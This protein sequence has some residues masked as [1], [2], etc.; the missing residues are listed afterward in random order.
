M[1]TRYYILLGI[2]VL[3]FYAAIGLPIYKECRSKGFSIYY[4]IFQMP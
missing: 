3:A 2:V 4:C 1:K